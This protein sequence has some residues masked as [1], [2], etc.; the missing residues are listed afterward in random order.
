MSQCFDHKTTLP[1]THRHFRLAIEISKTNLIVCGDLELKKD[2]LTKN[3]LGF[4]AYEFEMYDISVPH[5]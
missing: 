4:A 5:V 2:N 1:D 3:M